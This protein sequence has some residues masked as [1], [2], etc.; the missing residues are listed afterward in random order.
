[1]K[2]KTPRKAP[3][4]F[5]EKPHPGRIN[6]P[7]GGNVSQRK[8]PTQADRPEKVKTKIEAAKTAQSQGM[9]PNLKQSSQDDRFLPT[10]PSRIS[11]SGH[12]VNGHWT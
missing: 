10:L 3:R 1:M 2:Q 8:S 4:G 5:I 11:G 12:N 9:S 7:P 6:D